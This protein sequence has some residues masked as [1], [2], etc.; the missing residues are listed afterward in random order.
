MSYNCHVTES[1]TLLYRVGCESDRIKSSFCIDVHYCPY[2]SSCLLLQGILVSR[3]LGILQSHLMYL[4]S[5]VAFKKP[6]WECWLNSKEAGGHKWDEVI[7]PIYN[8]EKSYLGLCNRGD[9]LFTEWVVLIRHRKPVLNT[10]GP[11]FSLWWC[12]IRINS[13]EF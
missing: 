12:S 9:Y 4:S 6:W 13:Q 7:W 8:L 3:C 10:E 5:E 2:R 11:R 1:W